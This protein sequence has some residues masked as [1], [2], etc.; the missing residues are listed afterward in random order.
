MTR[1]VHFECPS[2]IGALNDNGL[3]AIVITCG[4]AGDISH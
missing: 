2:V 3:N 1:V 4:Q